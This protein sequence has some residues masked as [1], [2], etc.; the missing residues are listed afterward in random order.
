MDRSDTALDAARGAAAALMMQVLDQGRLLS[1]AVNDARGPVAQLDGPER[2]RAQRLC[3][4]AFRHLDRADAVLAPNLRKSPPSA[5]RCILR[6]ATVEMLADGAPPHAVVNA[7]VA[8]VRSSRRTAHLSGLVN[9]VLRKVAETPPEAWQRLPGQRLPDGWLRKRLVA[10]WGRSAVAAME[11]A[12]AAGAPLDITPRDATEDWASRLNATILPTGSLRLRRSGAVSELP[13]FDAG[14]WW[15]QDAAAAIPARVLAP[16]DGEHVLDLCAAPGGK[17][18]QLA[19]A[20]ARVTALD[21]SRWRMERL[22]ENLART[23][24]TAEIVIADAQ[25]WRPD[26]LFDAVLLDAPCTATGTIRRHPELPYVKRAADVPSLTDLQAR[27]LT[28][29]L[30]FVRPGG[31]LVYC[32]CSLLPEEGERQIRELPGLGA[33]VEVDPDAL[34]LPGIL[35]GWMTK[36]GGLRLRPDYWGDAGGMDGFYIAALRVPGS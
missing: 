33:G 24:L 15:V 6:I 13:G 23:D 17:T 10:A 34:A 19:A 31:R 12:H 36:E 3:T 14:A 20:G 32:T 29:A 21:N 7:A 35:P 28:R 4:T 25:E 30:S 18:L 16:R 9:A 2:A 1:E 5:V 26:T 22:R 27:L 11:A 8:Q